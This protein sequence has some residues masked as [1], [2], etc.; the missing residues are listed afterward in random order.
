MSP[1]T[2]NSVTKAILAVCE[3][4]GEDGAANRLVELVYD[5]LRRMAGAMMRREPAGHTLQ[6]TALVSQAFERLLTQDVMKDPRSRA[7]FFAAAARAMRQVLADHARGKRAEKRGGGRERIP[8]EEATVTFD[9]RDVAMIDLDDALRELAHHL[10]QEPS[11]V[12]P[13]AGI[14]GGGHGQL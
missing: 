1:E 14:R 8:L 10:R 5:E 2:G 12:V 13:L 9:G 6:P 7:Y 3:G 11:A 4:E